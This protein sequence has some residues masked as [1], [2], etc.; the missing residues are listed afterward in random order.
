MAV[1]VEEVF[2]TVQVQIDEPGAPT[3][4]YLGILDAGLRGDVL[5]H[6]SALVVIESVVLHGKM[7]EVDV[8]EPV[9]VIVGRVNAHV[10]LLLPIG[11]DGQSARKSRLLKSP[12]ALVHEQKIRGGIVRHHDVE[13]MVIVEVC[14]DDAEP[15]QAILVEGPAL[16]ADLAEGTVAFVSVEGISRTRN[17]PGPAHDSVSP[18]VAPRFR[19]AVQV[20]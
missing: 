11:A 4:S 20:D 7:R 14:P 1:G 15:E 2:P 12:V 3:H 10:G 6:E 19:Q 18:V 9:V 8:Q 17:S 5:E 16:L 13:V